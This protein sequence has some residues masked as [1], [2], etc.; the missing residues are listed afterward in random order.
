MVEV[1]LKQKCALWKLEILSTL[2]ISHE[3]LNLINTKP[4]Q[5]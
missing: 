2:I 4:L 5:F 3:K 1:L